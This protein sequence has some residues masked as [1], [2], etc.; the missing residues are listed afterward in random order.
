M[1]VN[2]TIRDIVLIERLDLEFRVG[3]T[4]LTGETGAGKS[5]LLESLGLATG[6]R[7]DSG[8]V[9][10]GAKQGSVT[11]EFRLD[12]AHPAFAVLAAQDFDRDGDPD[13][14]LLRRVV[15][16]DGRSR[17]FIDDQPASIG[18][19]RAV[20]EALVEVHGQ[21]SE[22]GLLSPALHP[23]LLDAFAGLT[24]E[25]AAL[26]ELH[27]AWRKA[28]R[29]LAEAVAAAERAREDE[30]YLR[31]VTG[32][33]DALEPVE[34]EA[35]TLAE[36]RA[37]LM[38]AEKV[39]E[40]LS[41]AEAMTAGHDGAE[42]ALRR[43]A[44]ALERVADRAGGRLDAALAALERAEVELN[45]AGLAIQAA[46]EAL[47]A[48]PGRLQEIDDRLFALRAAARK[49]R[50][51]VDDLPA[52][53]ERLR[54]RLASLDSAGDAIGRLKTEQDRAFERF[55]A[56]ARTL[57]EKRTAAAVALEAA[58]NRELAP[59]RLGNARFVCKVTPLE[60]AD[61]TAKGA[62]RIEFLIATNP[63][64]EPGA[65]NKIAS[66]GELSRL[67]LALKVVLAEAGSA[68]TLIF[69]EVDRGVGGATADAVGERLARLA[70][71]LQI[72]VVT[73][74][75]Q[76]AARGASHWVVRKSDSGTV[77][78]AVEPLDLPGRREEIARMLA[79]AEV[80]AEA[81][82][83]AAKLIEGSVE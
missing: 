15:G 78:V 59:L 38:Q 40:A 54:E 34:G 26:R 23:E 8:L 58:V 55:A 46:A 6:A 12:P 37:F 77:S 53:A 72:L 31:H 29:R 41:E 81:R 60:S 63:G 32:E 18:L 74:S 49:H 71:E 20:G 44:R 56:S 69:D 83:A 76:V 65:L 30:D 7:A 36:S 67:M 68:P 82:A 45:E 10:Q 57:G 22:Q 80:T 73:H 11:A 28:E 13:R 43:A 21:N 5:I 42:A 4:A 47:N 39:G 61:W 16:A 50:C 35:E 51:E 2:L 62:E 27:G 19:L 79:G 64:A 14:L 33:L 17:A 3:L 25:A 24:V 9:R 66:G 70:R 75:P 52:L 48:E 1:L